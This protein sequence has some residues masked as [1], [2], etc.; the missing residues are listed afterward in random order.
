MLMK[1]AAPHDVTYPRLDPETCHFAKQVAPGH[2]V[3]ALEQDGRDWWVKSGMPELGSLS[4]ALMAF[5]AAV[6]NATRIR[7]WPSRIICQTTV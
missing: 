2:D 6:I 3:Y 7:R 4:K 1:P 5:A